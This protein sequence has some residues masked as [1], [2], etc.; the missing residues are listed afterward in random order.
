VLLHPGFVAHGMRPL[1]DDA[2]LAAGRRLVRYH[3]R[4]YDASDPAP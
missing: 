3:P 1:F 2:T 4:G